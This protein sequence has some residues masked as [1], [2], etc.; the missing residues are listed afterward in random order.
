MVDRALA[1]LTAAARRPRPSAS[2][3]RRGGFLKLMPYRS[4]KRQIAEIDVCRDRRA[5]KEAARIL[6]TR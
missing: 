3:R 2:V 4:R 6:S 5:P 1:A